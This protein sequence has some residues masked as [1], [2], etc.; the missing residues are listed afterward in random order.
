MNPQTTPNTNIIAAKTQLH[1]AVTRLTA[2]QPTPHNNTT[3]YQPSLYHCLTTELPG[4]L[5]GNNKTPPKSMPPLWIDATDLLT[6][7]DTTTYKWSPQR[8]TTPQRLHHLTETGW[9][10]QDTPHVHKIATTINQWCENIL[11]LLNPKPN[12]HIAAPCPECNQHT[13]HTKDPAGEL[14]R[15]PALKIDADTGATCQACETF[16]APD[17]FI[18]L[19]HQL[20]LTPQGVHE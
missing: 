3:I 16:W 9:R 20:G 5:N 4:T 14:V 8:G 12:K 17:K 15:R 19:A 7:I 11:N 2:K 18:T 1:T 13:I 6:I 10:P